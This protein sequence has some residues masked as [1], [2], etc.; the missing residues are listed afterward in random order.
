MISTQR[1]VSSAKEH[2]AETTH[3]LVKKETT[4]E[5]YGNTASSKPDSW[6]LHKKTPLQLIFFLSTHLCVDMP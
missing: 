1:V 4:T 2:T 6:Y 3:S 5:N